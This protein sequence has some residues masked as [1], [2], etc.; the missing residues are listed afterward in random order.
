MFC[1]KQ[2]EKSLVNTTCVIG[3]IG[4]GFPR[5][6]IFENVKIT[7]HAGERQ[8]DLMLDV[9]QIRP[10]ITF[11]KSF[12]IQG[13]LY[14]GTIRARLDLNNTE[15]SYKLVDVVLNNLN[16]TTISKD[17]GLEERKIT[18]SMSG[19]G[20]W[21]AEWGVPEQG[22]GKARIK[23]NKGSIDFL[24]PV[25][26]L[27]TLRYEHINFDIQHEQQLKILSGKL[28]GVDLKSDFEGNIQ[29][30]NSLFDSRLNITGS[31]ELSRALLQKNP[32]EAK[33]VKLYAKKYK[34]KALPFRINGMIS[35]PTLRFN[36]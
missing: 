1:E 25:L 26:S 32:L 8:S 24:Q 28:S 36:R 9:I 20:Y 2:I 22:T 3:K 29:V 23:I 4:Y 21:Q 19:S 27:S 16:L 35:S 31:L 30:M 14:S 11:W 12:R 7:K 34:T 17:Q 13:T 5:S 33:M 6:I 18:G 15:K 10:R